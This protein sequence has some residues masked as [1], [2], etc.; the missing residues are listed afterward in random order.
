MAISFKKVWRD[1]HFRKDRDNAV[2]LGLSTQGRSEN[3][4]ENEKPD[5]ES[6]YLWQK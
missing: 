5:D 1:P 2:G 4:E 3:T 6:I